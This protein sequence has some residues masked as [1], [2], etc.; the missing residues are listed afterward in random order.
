MKF[1]AKPTINWRKP[2]QRH[3]VQ[4]KKELSERNQKQNKPTGKRQ[5][6]QL[7]IGISKRGQLLTSK[8][9][10]GILKPRIIIM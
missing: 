2:F 10:S 8:S 5:Y 3:V 7:E 6:P 9:K 1:K 4:L